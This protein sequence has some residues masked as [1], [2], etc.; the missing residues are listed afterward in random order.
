MSAGQPTLEIPVPQFQFGK[1]IWTQS[2]QTKTGRCVIYFVYFKCTLCFLSR[3]G[4]KS[5]PK[6]CI[7]RAMSPAANGNS[8][9][10]WWTQR[11]FPSPK[12]Q[13]TAN[14][15]PQKTAKLGLGW[16]A[17]DSLIIENRKKTL[18]KTNGTQIFTARMA[19]QSLKQ[20]D[21]STLHQDLPK[22]SAFMMHIDSWI[23]I[24]ILHY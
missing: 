1:H 6:Q 18:L 9:L 12:P 24:C 17:S 2:K 10:C 4:F 20:I 23:L 21:P 22:K 15:K 11:K 7:S 5:F 16:R 14:P 19:L 13:K 3:K 8:P